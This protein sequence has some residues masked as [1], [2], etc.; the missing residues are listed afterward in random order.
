MDRARSTPSKV[1]GAQ[2]VG[3]GRISPEVAH[4]LQMALELSNPYGAALEVLAGPAMAGI[5]RP[6]PKGFA[7]AVFR[8]QEGPR[9]TLESSQRDTLT[10]I[11]KGPPSWPSVPLER[12]VRIRVTLIDE[13]LVVDDAIGTFEIGHDDLVAAVRSGHVRLFLLR[14]RKVVLDRRELFVLRLDCLPRRGGLS[15]LTVA[16]PLLIHPALAAGRPARRCGLRRQRLTATREGQR[17][18]REQNSSRNL[19][20]RP[21]LRSTRHQ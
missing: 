18:R 15:V 20:R 16:V 13:V 4:G 10:P 14:L 12:D 11:W 17:A 9:A 21:R 19:R 8:G 5:E 2:W 6:E 3:T 1:G 7:A